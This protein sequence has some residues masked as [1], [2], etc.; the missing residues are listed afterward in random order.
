M[1]FFSEYI[2]VTLPEVSSDQKKNKKKSSKEKKLKF[3]YYINIKDIEYIQE[4][5]NCNYFI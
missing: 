4:R 3:L 5:E 2:M 1:H